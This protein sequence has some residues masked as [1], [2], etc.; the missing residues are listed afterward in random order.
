MKPKTLIKFRKHA[1][2]IEILNIVACFLNLFI[3]LDFIT[4]TSFVITIFFFFSM[5]YFWQCPYCELQLPIK[6]DVDNDFT[7]S[8]TCPHCG[9][10]IE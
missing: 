9:K 7:D 10:R 3:N 2:T 6:F 1:L 4:I 5:F 8:Y